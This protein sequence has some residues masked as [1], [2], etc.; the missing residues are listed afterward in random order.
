MVKQQL[1]SLESIDTFY[2]DDCQL[3]GIQTK[4]GATQLCYTLEAHLGMPFHRKLTND[5]AINFI[6]GKDS[7]LGI[8]G[9]LFENVPVE[10][11]VHFALFE[12]QL[13]FSDAHIYIYQNQQRGYF[14][15]PEQKQFQ[16]FMLIQDECLQLAR[17]PLQHWI[18]QI[19]DIHSCRRIDIEALGKSKENLI[20]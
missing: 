9:T 18:N 13:S 11:L 7:G 17:Q 20:I 19:P 14:L 1:L 4:L 16:Y 6:S 3:L 8:A 15:I 5:V 12:H 10:E 2:F